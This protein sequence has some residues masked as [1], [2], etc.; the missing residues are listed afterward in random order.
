MKEIWE[1]YKIPIIFAGAGLLLAIL[2]I[3]IGF[4][5][6]LLLLVFTYLGAYL[7]FYLLGIGFFDRFTM[8]R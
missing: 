5:K 7:G 1:A 3:T 6:T 2:L 8:R 4:L